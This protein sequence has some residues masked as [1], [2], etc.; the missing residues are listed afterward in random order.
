MKSQLKNKSGLVKKNMNITAHVAE[1]IKGLSKK[2]N[3]K[4]KTSKLTKTLT[5]K[6]L[7]AKPNVMTEDDIDNLFRK[8]SKEKESAQV[9]TKVST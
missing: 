6:T 4:S 2:T 9:P 8:N 7:N 3:W 1:A 5:G